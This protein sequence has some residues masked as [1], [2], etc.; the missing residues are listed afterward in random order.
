[1]LKYNLTEFLLV[2]ISSCNVIS[3]DVIVSISYYVC[4]I[5]LPPTYEITFNI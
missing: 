4:V 2:S 1:M 5:F 3:S